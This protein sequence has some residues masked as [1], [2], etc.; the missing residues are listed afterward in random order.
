MRHRTTKRILILRAASAE[1]VTRE[2]RDLLTDGGDFSVSVHIRAPTEAG[3]AGE[4]WAEPPSAILLIVQREEIDAAGTLNQLRASPATAAVPIVVVAEEEP[5][6]DHVTEWLEGG[7]SDFLTRPF[8][9]C[10]VLPR[11]WHV[12]GPARE[13]EMAVANLKEKLG[14]AQIIG[15]SPAFLAEVKNIPMVARYPASVLIQGETGTGKELIAR[16]I[17]HLSARSSQPFIAVSCAGI[18]ESLAENELFGH[19]KGAYTGATHPQRGLV[20]EAH[21]GTLLLDDVDCLTPSIQAKLLRFLQD[22]EYRTLGSPRLFKADVRI[23]ASSNLDLGD[24]ASRGRFRL[25]LYHRLNVVPI[26]LPPL[27]E[28]VEDI[29]L[30]AEHFLAR[31]A[32]D[33]G[34]V[35]PRLTARVMDIL[36]AY[37]WPGNVRELE[38]VI[39]RAL[40]LSGGNALEPSALMLPMLEQCHGSLSFQDAKA[41][42]IRRFERTYLERQLRACSGN[43]SRAARAS[44]KQRRAFFELVRKH[45]I[46]VDQFRP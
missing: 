10:D 11:L 25:D 45:N 44:G 35:P 39:E 26:R 20:A 5:T 15:Q 17:H 32:E 40:I 36:L 21:G 43:L 6:P 19:A 27:R 2:L 12:V 30:L 14:L 1:T 33:L 18:P 23:I 7:A 8:R 31:R 28:R 29:P 13:E 46:D 38:H 4:I 22:K 3:F 37:D 16:C 42:V 24:E 41:Q 34:I 9:P